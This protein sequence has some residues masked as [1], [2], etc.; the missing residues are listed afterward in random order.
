MWNFSY[1]REFLLRSIII[2]PE[3]EVKEEKLY[4]TRITT[5]KVP[6][7]LFHLT[8]FRTICGFILTKTKIR[9]CAF[10][11]YMRT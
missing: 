11:L 4:T 7:L 9:N 1:S 2:L 6:V 3:N 10:I 8:S 5:E